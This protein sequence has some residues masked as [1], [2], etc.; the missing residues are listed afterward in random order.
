MK[1]KNQ[2]QNKFMK[3]GT[4][5]GDI[6]VQLNVYKLPPFGLLILEILLLSAL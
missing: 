1:N 2:I 5:L 3:V 6:A 4:D